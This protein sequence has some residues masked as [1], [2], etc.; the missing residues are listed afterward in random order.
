[1]TVSVFAP[2]KINLTLHVTGQRDDG[3]HL[4][5]SL[6][7]FAPVGDYLTIQD[8]NTL[9]LT[10]EGPEAAGIPADMN[11]LVMKVA[12]ILADG[13]GAAITLNKYLPVASGI[14]GGSADAAAAIR[15]L[16]GYW[17]HEAKN[18]GLFVPEGDALKH[19]ARQFLSIGADIPMCLLPRQQRVRGIGEDIQQVEF[20][21]LPALLV[22]PRVA[23]STKE[24]FRG[25]KLNTNPPMEELLPDFESITEFTSWLAKQRNDLE[26][27]ACKHCPEIGNVLD[28]L[29]GLDGCLLSRMSG[30]GATCF[31]IF[32]T[33]E[34]AQVVGRKLLR[35]Q[36]RWWIAGGLLGD[37]VEKSAPKFS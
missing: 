15:A 29:A 26:T 31:A 33:P 19:L 8:G 36:P 25:L 32:E 23:V 24:V 18:V 21:P 3:Y 20:P 12:E 37:W 2:A 9:S 28:K 6:V 27:P 4:I 13:S 14:G 1:M 35:D 5:D 34:I 17:N 7:A 10:V 30:S 11:N 22:N 16:S